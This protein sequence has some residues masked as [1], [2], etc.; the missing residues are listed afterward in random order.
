MKDLM[1][2]ED[3]YK[4]LV[5]DCR[6]II[7]EAVFSSNWSLVEGYH[8]VG[9][10]IN[11]DITRLKKQ[12]GSDL[13][14]TLS[15][16]SKLIGLGERTL[17]RCVQFYEKYPKLDK[18]PEGRAITWNKLINNYLTTPREKQDKVSI[19]VGELIKIEREESIEEESLVGTIEY[20][21]CPR[22]HGTGRVKNETSN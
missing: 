2:T 12:G 6:A 10:R 19:E 15:A 14:E 21:I 7:T 11:I 5:D 16:L 3:W 13:S 20:I 22:C 9:E 18:V 17:Y 4:S 8:E 1:M